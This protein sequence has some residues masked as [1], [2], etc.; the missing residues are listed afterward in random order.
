MEKWA[1]SI[2]A[3][4]DRPSSPLRPP[5]RWPWSIELLWLAMPLFVVAIRTLLQPVSPEDYWWP[6]AMG[7]L[8]WQG[9]WPDRA[10]FLYTLPV[11]QPFYS[12][13]WLSQWAMAGLAHVSHVANH[14]AH[15]GLLLGAWLLLVVAA[16]RRGGVPIVVGIGA[17]IA[18]YM[19]AGGLAVRAQMFAY[20]LF[21]G[22]AV[23]VLDQARDHR[24]WRW[25][26]MV[27]VAALWANVHGTFVLAPLLV[28]AAGAGVIV[29]RW[30]KGTLRRATLV[31]WGAGGVAIMA[32]TVVCPGGIDNLLYLGGYVE[33]TKGGAFVVE[34]QPP[35]FTAPQGIVFWGALLASIGW[36]GRYRDIRW[37]ELAVF[38]LVTA[39]TIGSVRAILW[40]GIVWVLVF[41]PVV[42]RRFAARLARDEEPSTA[43]GIV[44]AGLLGAMVVAVVLALPGAPLFQKVETELLWGHPRL[45]TDEADL[46]VFSSKNPVD[47]VRDVLADDPGRIFHHQHVGSLIEWELLQ[48]HAPD[49]VPRIVYVDQRLELFSVDRW[50]EY[51]QVSK[52]NDGW[53]D[54]LRRHDVRTLILHPDE[55]R[56]LIDALEETPDI[57][58]TRTAGEWRVYRLP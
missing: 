33:A 41:T 28:G 51:Y 44:N 56:P 40:W 2:D 45:K 15:V 32:A 49:E 34:W 8:I 55:Q 7:E 22:F 58:L 36:I 18:H 16:L 1:S 4:S 30:R 37:P 24:P 39:I 19:A 25:A 11:D 5:W 54:V 9:D 53:R 26:A 23:L 42:S 17:A 27:G 48:T 14:F 52:A 6:L 35:P 43:S 10:L 38:S 50:L 3:M 46:R 47:L 20:P 13:A 57:E 31:R 12:Q 21:V 29:Q